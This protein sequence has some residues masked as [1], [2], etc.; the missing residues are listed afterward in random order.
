MI[1]GDRAHLRPTG[2]VQ[3]FEGG[4]AVV[5]QKNMVV[6]SG[7]EALVRALLSGE[8]LESIVLANNQGATVSAA[9]RLAGVPL[10]IGT[11]GTD[12]DAGL[13][14]VQIPD[15]DGLLTAF[16]VSAQLVPT[17]SGTYDTAG[18]LMSSGLLVAATAFTARP[19]TASS[20][21]LVRWTLRLR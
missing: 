11:V 20:P 2:H 10:V 21:I 9:M 3:I 13:E 4:D 5:D 12:L 15:D 8:Q 7:Y 1:L 14:P 6:N 19:F 18:L 16:R 17:T